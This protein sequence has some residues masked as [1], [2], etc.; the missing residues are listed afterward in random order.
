MATWDSLNDRLIE[1]SVSYIGSLCSE[2]NRPLRYL[3][4]ESMPDLPDFYVAYHNPHRYDVAWAVLQ[5][6]R[7]L[8]IDDGFIDWLNSLPQTRHLTPRPHHK[9]LA[10][11]DPFLEHLSKL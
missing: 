8:E 11:A 6:C 1:C 10:L 5:R 2:F 4:F 9:A 3:N 7:E